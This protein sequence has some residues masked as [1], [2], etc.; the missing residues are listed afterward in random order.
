[1]RNHLE[2]RGEALARVGHGFEAAEDLLLLERFPTLQRRLQQRIARGE[3]PVEAA[4]GDA[5]APRQGFDRDC[6]DALFGDQVQRGL[7]PVV[8]TEAAA[9]RF[10]GGLFRSIRHDRSV[11]IRSRLCRRALAGSAPCGRGFSADYRG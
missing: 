4:L 3:M 1:V 5:E 11:S 2:Q 9:L 6:G 10:G 8:G 7:G